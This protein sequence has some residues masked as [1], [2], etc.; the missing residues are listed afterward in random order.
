MEAFPTRLL[1]FVEQAM[2]SVRRAVARYSSKFS[3]RWYTLHQHIILLCLKIRK[4]TT[5]RRLLDELIEMPRIRSALD[6][7]EI[8]SPS[9]LCEAF[10]RLDMA[11]WRVLLDLSVTVLPTN[12]VIGEALEDRFPGDYVS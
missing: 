12:G 10:N 2:H 4:S 7:E 1:R 5:Y 6:V 3:K 9:T 11:V 8:P